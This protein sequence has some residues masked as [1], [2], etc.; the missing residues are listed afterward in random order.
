MSLL[1]FL[2]NIPGIGRLTAFTGEK[3]RGEKNPLPDND[4]AEHAQDT[5]ENI[6]TEAAI[7]DEETKKENAEDANREKH[8]PGTARARPDIKSGIKN[9]NIRFNMEKCDTDEKDK[10][11]KGHGYKKLK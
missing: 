6:T 8:Q 9:F 10:G 11:R 4:R 2:R 3:G 5:M 7:I 1:S